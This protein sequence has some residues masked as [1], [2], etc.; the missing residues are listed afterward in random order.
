VSKM[1]GIIA[2]EYCGSRFLSKRK[3][4]RFCTQN[5]QVSCYEAR[6]TV[7]RHKNISAEDILS[8][9]GVP[10]IFKPF[11]EEFLNGF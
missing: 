5:C 11:A 9:L 6:R 3:T 2:C 7:Q 8:T 1:N 4:Q 10:D